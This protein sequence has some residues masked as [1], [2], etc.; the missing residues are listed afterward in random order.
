MSGDLFV[1]EGKTDGEWWKIWG[2]KT[3]D[4]LLLEGFSSEY[5]EIRAADLILDHLTK[6]IAPS[7]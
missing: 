6:L 3:S 5:L 4:G 7:P 2:K 1:L